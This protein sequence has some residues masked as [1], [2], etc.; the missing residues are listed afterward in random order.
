MLS[1][2][3]LELLYDLSSPYSYLTSTQIEG[4]AARAGV[5]LVLK[6]FAL[7][8]VF[9][10][11]GIT[12]SSQIPERRKYMEQDLQRWA[13]RYG[14]P[15]QVP[16]PFPTNSILANRAALA[17]DEIG[18]QPKAM[19]ALFR[20]YFADGKD[21][22]LPENV[23]AALT[24][25]GLDGAAL[26]ARAQ[27]QPVKDRLRQ[28]TDEAIRRGAFGAPTIF[29]GEEMFWGNDRLDFVEEAV[30]AASK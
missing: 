10:E 24:G 3:D 22:A 8:A 13:K 25:A 12:S 28:I 16:T 20:R 7:G 19:A 6:P 30:R 9:K 29:V 2:M 27:T 21:L 5:R 23:I 18:E 15:F 26:V 17:A 1:K 11:Q 14:V 4:L